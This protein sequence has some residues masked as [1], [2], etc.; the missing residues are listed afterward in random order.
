MLRDHGLLK[1]WY[2]L[3]HV[4]SGRFEPVGQA[5]S[6]NDGDFFKIYTLI[7]IGQVGVAQNYASVGGEGLND[8]VGPMDKNS[9]APIALK[10]VKGVGVVQSKSPVAEQGN[11]RIPVSFYVELNT[12]RS[13][14]VF[15]FV[16]F[17]PVFPGTA[18]ITLDEV[19]S[20]V[21]TVQ[22]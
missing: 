20:T 4:I 18:G 12:L 11:F 6:N 14:T 3:R 22:I 10:I 15:L 13:L 16:F 21:I 2:K 9:V 1:K 5:F 19:V 17:S 7:K 8:P